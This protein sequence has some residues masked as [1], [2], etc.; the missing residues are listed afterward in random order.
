MLESI[1]VQHTDT[2][3]HTLIHTLTQYI[4]T[5]TFS[6]IHTRMHT[7]RLTYA[8]FH[9]HSLTHMLT[10]V[11]HPHT[12]VTRTFSQ[13]HTD[14]LIHAHT[15]SHASS[16]T[17]PYNF[18]GARIKE[19]TTGSGW[20]RQDLRREER[21]GFNTPSQGPLSARSWEVIGKPALISQQMLGNRNRL[22]ASWAFAASYL[23]VLSEWGGHGQSRSCYRAKELSSMPESQVKCGWRG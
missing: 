6:H 5:Y 12:H 19:A 13:T 23:T 16:Y 15:C 18:C 7:D 11:S 1:L 9:A 10:N 14:K 8:D 2:C 4:L 3:S 22:L 21:K 20:E 17:Y